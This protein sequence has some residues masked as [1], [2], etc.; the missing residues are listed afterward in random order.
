MASSIKP[1][2]HNISLRRQRR[3]EPLRPQITMHKKFGEDRTCSSGDNYDRG[4][5]DRH[6]V[7][8]SLE[9]SV[10]RIAGGCISADV[11]L[12]AVPPELV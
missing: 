1:E 4:Q 8:R 2:V 12:A 3:M 6:A 7:T 9:Y 10:L 11:T 5:T